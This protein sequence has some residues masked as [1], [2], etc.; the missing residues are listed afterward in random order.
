MLTQVIV[1]M[2]KELKEQAL[3]KLKKQGLTLS[4]FF[5]AVTYAFVAGDLDIQLVQKRP[6]SLTKYLKVK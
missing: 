1:K 2:D 6:F 4:Q 3:K 5:R